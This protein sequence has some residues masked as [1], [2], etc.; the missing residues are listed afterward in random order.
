MEAMLTALTPPLTDDGE[1]NQGFLRDDALLVVVIITDEE[2][3]HETMDDACNGMPL[4]GSP[5]DPGSW[6]DQMVEIKGKEE[7]VVVL[8]LVGPDGRMAPMCPAL[9][10]CNGGIVGAEVA[11]RILEFTSM[12]TFGFVGQVCGDYGPIFQESISVIKT[13]CDEFE[14]VG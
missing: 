4:P 11:R 13:A 1:C 8:S 5:G 9:D 3:D 6:F 14:P 10:K 12:F 2:D 7:S